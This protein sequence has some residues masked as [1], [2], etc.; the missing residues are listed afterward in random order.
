[1]AL[2]MTHTYDILDQATAPPGWFVY[3]INEARR[4]VWSL[5]ISLWVLVE[6]KDDDKLIEYRPFVVGRRGQIVD[7]SISDDEVLC[8]LPPGLDHKVFVFGLL[9]EEQRG[10]IEIVTTTN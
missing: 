1:M 10:D 4:E 9:P 5:P 7:Y 8:V 6:H 3:Y 2:D